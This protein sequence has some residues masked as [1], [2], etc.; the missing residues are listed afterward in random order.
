M[1]VATRPL[2]KGEGSCASMKPVGAPELLAGGPS[3]PVGVVGISEPSAPRSLPSDRDGHAFPPLPI[4]PESTAEEPTKVAASS[5]RPARKIPVRVGIQGDVSMVGS[6][7]Q[8]TLTMGLR[9][10][11]SGLLVKAQ[12]APLVPDTSPFPVIDLA[13]QCSPKSGSSVCY[14]GFWGRSLASGR[15]RCPLGLMPVFVRSQ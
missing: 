6:T 1:E 4:A 10:S 7:V 13:D 14:G 11:V 5:K 8:E 12:V 2:E 15:L 9:D 3:A